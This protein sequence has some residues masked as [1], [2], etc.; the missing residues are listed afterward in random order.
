MKRHLILVVALSVTSCA[1]SPMREPTSPHGEG[2]EEAH[3]SARKRVSLAEPGRKFEPEQR[4]DLS[5]EA[6]VRKLKGTPFGEQE[7]TEFWTRKG[8]RLT[9]KEERYMSTVDTLAAEGKIKKTAHWS[10]TPF[11]GVYETQEALTI[12]G[13]RIAEH[14]EFW[15]E[16]C[17]N[18]DEIHVG[19][20]Y[21]R[22][23]AGYQE[24][25][26]GHADQQSDSREGELRAGRERR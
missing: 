11:N 21:F 12:E 1:E 7:I 9:K 26:Q 4:W 2:S 13:T 20:P 3:E 16:F 10:Q 17:E 23:I 24:E 14:T 6:A 18:E 15:M 22:R 25:H 5:E 8:W 19:A